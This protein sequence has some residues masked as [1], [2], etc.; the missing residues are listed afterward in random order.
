MVERLVP[1]DL[2][3]IALAD[4]LPHLLGYRAF[5]SDVDK[6]TTGAK[7]MLTG[8]TIE[9][10][11]VKNAD[12]T[13][14]MPGRVCSWKAGYAGTQIDDYCGALGKG[15]GVVDPYVGSSGVAAGKH[16]WLITKGPADC[17]G[18]GTSITAGNQLM[19]GATG[20]VQPYAS[21]AEQAVARMGVALAN[22]AAS[23][24]TLFRAL[25]DFNY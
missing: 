7:T 12:T 22:C 6:D 13:A 2:G 8:M 5:F 15:A 14:V 20:Y 19:T 25:V 21:G 10:V 1:Y 4:E 18:D 23:A 17:R 11:W 9:A 3:S 16:F 24:G